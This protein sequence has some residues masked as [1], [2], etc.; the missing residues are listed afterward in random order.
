M[1][2]LN[3]VRFTPGSA[4][5]HYQQEATCKLQDWTKLSAAYTQLVPG[6]ICLGMIFAL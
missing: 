4:S 1:V 5:A 2:S 3:Q 6:R